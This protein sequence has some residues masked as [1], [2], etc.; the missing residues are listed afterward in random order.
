MRW[1]FKGIKFEPKDGHE[2]IEQYFIQQK[3]AE[4]GY[5]FDGLTLD[6]LEVE[7]FMLIAKTFEEEK[8]KENAKKTRKK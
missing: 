6:V 1:V 8:N 5:K 4:L 3:M 7:A 2:Y